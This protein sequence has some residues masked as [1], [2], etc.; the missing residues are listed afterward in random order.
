MS[1]APAEGPADLLIYAMT[2]WAITAWA[3]TTAVT[4]Q[5]TAEPGRPIFFDPGLGS[6]SRHRSA[7][8]TARS[9]HVS[10]K[11][12]EP[13]A[14]PSANVVS[15]STPAGHGAADERNVPRSHDVHVPLDARSFPTPRARA[16]ARRT[17]KMSPK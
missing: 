17:P 8:G 15:P 11:T 5:A 6:A 13:P 7:V 12:R 14:P 4:T 1:R 9:Q 16:R 10:P 3:I 2:V